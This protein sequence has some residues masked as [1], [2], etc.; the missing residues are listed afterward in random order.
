[1]QHRRS[2]RLARYDYTWNGAYFVT[3]CTK[4][5][6]LL[7]GEIADEAVRLSDFGRIVEQR[8]IDIPK[9]FDGVTIDEYVVMSNHIHGII[10]IDRSVTVGAQHAAPLPTQ[11]FGVPPGSL[12]AIVRSFKSAST[13]L[14][15]EKRHT[16]GE[17]VWQRNY[18]EHVIR[19]DIDL[20]RVRSYIADNPRKWAEDVE[21]PV[22]LGQWSDQ[23]PT[24][25]AS[26]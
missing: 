6:E 14:I 20:D 12:G 15:N 23:Q 7:L 16:P 9:H 21:N 13:K 24:A 8:W 11:R 17:P 1:M 10:V 26:R 25:G 5:R 18:Y 2:A 19:Q 3:I 4:N 22:S